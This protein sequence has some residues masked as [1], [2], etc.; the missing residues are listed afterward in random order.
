MD[1]AGEILIDR[2][3]QVIGTD[4]KLIGSISNLVCQG[5]IFFVK[6]STGN[7]IYITFGG[8]EP[9]SKSYHVV[10]TDTFPVFD[11]NV[12][13]GDVKAVCSNASGLLSTYARGGFWEGVNPQ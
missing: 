12:V 3:E 13:I 7:E 9:S 1:K 2:S 8:R 6:R 10:L 11:D 4:T 5:K